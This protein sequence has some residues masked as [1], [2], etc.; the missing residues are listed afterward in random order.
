[1]RKRVIVDFYRVLL[2]GNPFH[3]FTEVLR[4]IAGIADLQARNREIFGDTYR[5]QEFT[6]TGMVACGDLLKIRMD[7]LPVKASLEGP[8][9]ELGLDDDEGIGEESAFLFDSRL[10]VL[11]HQR[12]RSG[13]SASRMVAYVCQAS[14]VD[15]QPVFE[16]IVNVD[17][18]REIMGMTRHSR[19]EIKCARADNAELWQGDDSASAAMRQMSELNAPMLTLTASCGRS[20][21]LLDTDFVQGLVNAVRPLLNRRDQVVTKLEITGKSD[22][23]SE[24]LVVDLV[25]DR[26]IETGAVEVGRS[27]NVTFAV[28]KRLIEE[29]YDHRR[30][31]LRSMFASQNE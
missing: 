14:E 15:D 12:N 20:D 22:D 24:R 4:H 18:Y 11:A 27:R 30:Q 29:A 2:N 26:M 8:I 17:A 23:D 28:R 19:L 5:L 6:E 1:M 31:E 9:N 16:P 3:R 7:N 21:Q 10:A 13:V 25:R